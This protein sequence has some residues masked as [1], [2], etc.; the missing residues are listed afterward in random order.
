MKRYRNKRRTPKII[1]Y[2]ISNTDIAEYFGYSS[3]ETF[4]NSSSKARIIQGI[5]SIIECIEKFKQI[6]N[7]TCYI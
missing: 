4:N 5:E 2:K 3:V 1:E 6:N 7:K